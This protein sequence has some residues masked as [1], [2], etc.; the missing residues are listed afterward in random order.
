MKK[1]RPKFYVIILFAS[2]I[3]IIAAVILALTSY[4][5]N[6]DI[7]AGCLG[8]SGTLLFGVSIFF[9]SPLKK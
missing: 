2:A 5:Y 7:L 9:V 1:V 8:I 4:D 3:L 6:K